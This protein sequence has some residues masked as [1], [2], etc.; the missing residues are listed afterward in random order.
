MA[1]PDGPMMDRIIEERKRDALRVAQQHRLLCQAR[2]GR[3][4]RLSRRLSRLMRELGHWLV[5]TGKR[6]EQYHLPQAAS[7]GTVVGEVSTR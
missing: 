4:V 1:F 2:S 6:L 5:A 7:D 3:R